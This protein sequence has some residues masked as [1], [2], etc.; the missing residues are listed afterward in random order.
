VT[1]LDIAKRR[2]EKEKDIVEL[3]TCAAVRLA[4]I[5]PDSHALV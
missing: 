4:A 5:L 1:A 2:D 3:L